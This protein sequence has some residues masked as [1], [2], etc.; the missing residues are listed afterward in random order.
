[1]NRFVLLRHETPPG[2][3][4]PS[5]WDLMLE[6]GDHLKTWTLWE[7]P[8]IGKPNIAVPDFDHRLH[9][10]SY[11][12][13]ISNNRGSV[14]QIDRG[15]YTDLVHSKSAVQCSLNGTTLT[16]KLTLMIQISS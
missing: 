12:G 4:K 16:G 9:Y 5:H 13:P 11:E 8:V 14:R 1:M 2:Y 6:H 7:M 3:V 10:L 15:T